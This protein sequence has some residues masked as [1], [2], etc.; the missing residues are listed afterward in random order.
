MA[1]GKSPFESKSLASLLRR[2]VEEPPDP[3]PPRSVCLSLFPQASRNSPP[4][5]R[6]G[7]RE[8]PQHVAIAPMVLLL[9]A[10]R[11]CCWPHDCPQ[12]HWHGLQKRCPFV[13]W[14]SSP[15]Q[16]LHPHQPPAPAAPPSAR[17]R[18]R[19]EKDP[20]RPFRAVVSS[21]LGWCCGP[22]RSKRREEGTGGSGGG[23]FRANLRERLLPARAVSQ[24]GRGA[25]GRLRGAEADV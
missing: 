6:Q 13:R 10:G 5:A 7:P 21:S 24:D 8:T 14:R 25:G 15:T 11:C 12:W 4:L 18:N 23:A 3:L 9:L 19:A 16:H 17:R 1:A 2:I 20:S 22:N